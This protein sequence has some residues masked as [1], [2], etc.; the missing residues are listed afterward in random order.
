MGLLGGRKSRSTGKANTKPSTSSQAQGNGSSGAPAKE[1]GSGPNT[2]VTYYMDTENAKIDCKKDKDEV[3]KKC[4]PDDKNKHRGKGKPKS[5]KDTGSDANWVLDHC[6]PLMVQ[7]GE[8]FTEWLEDFKD[9]DGALRQLAQE[10]GDNVISQLE[11]E[12]LE[13]AGK[14]IAKMAIRRGLTGWIPVVGWIMTAVDI[15]VTAIDVA[16]KVSELKE[17]VAQLKDTVKNL[18]EQAGKIT[19]TLDK[20]KDKL[21]D[22]GKLSKEEQGKVAREVMADVQSGYAAAAPCLRARKC[23]LVPFNKDLADK[24][25]GKGC[26][27]GQT[28]HHLLPD[29]MFRDPA[30]SE[31]FKQEWKSNPANRDKNGKLKSIRRD[32]LQK[33]ACWDGYSEGASPTICAEGANQHSGSHGMLHGLTGT[34]LGALGYSKKTEMRYIDARDL[35]LDEVSRLYGCSKKCLQAQL[36]AYY[37]GKAASNKPDCPDCHNAKVVPNSGMGGE[38][39][40]KP[41]DKPQQGNDAFEA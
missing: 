9:I 34:K 28:G 16:S 35:I 5:R 30:G 27:P 29:A 37:C 31:A 26:C 22:F 19:S 25:A 41:E 21:K 18:Q 14:Q 40:A 2:P 32:Q 17:T 36:D 1:S 33:K 7:P 24:W 38:Q 23:M 11:K 13:H 12:I 10:L 20:Y 15:A 6:G 8:N 39:P 4:A 3:E